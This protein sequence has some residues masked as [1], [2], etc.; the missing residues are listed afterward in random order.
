VL[1]ALVA[2]V[3][4]ISGRRLAA[5]PVKRAA[6]QMHHGFDVKRIGAHTVNDGAG[7]AVEIEFA[8]VAPDFAL[9]F[10]FTQNSAKSGLIFFKIIGA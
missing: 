6:M 4:A 1:N 10:R 8:V 3:E 2:P 5:Q 9:A 7:K